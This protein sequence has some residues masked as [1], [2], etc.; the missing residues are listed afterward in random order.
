VLRVDD[1]GLPRV[2]LYRDAAGALKG[3]ALV[4][5]A[6]PLSVQMAEDY[7]D[8]TEFAPGFTVAVKRAEFTARPAPTQ[9][10][11]T[12]AGNGGGGNSDGEQ[13]EN[14]EEDGEGGAKRA[15]PAVTVS[16]AAA[17]AAAAAT[18]AARRKAKSVAARAQ[19]Q[20]LSW[21]D[22]GG[23]G[24]RIVSILYAFSPAAA[25]ASGDADGYYRR[26][27]AVFEDELERACGTLHKLTVFRGNEL[28][29]I[30]AKFK[31][32]E[33]AAAC[34]RLMNNRVFPPPAAGADT[35]V[36]QRL[37]CTYFDG[38]TNYKVEE[39]GG[40]TEEQRLE[41]F[42]D[43]LERED[44]AGAAPAAQDAEVDAALRAME[45][46]AAR[47]AATAVNDSSSDSDGVAGEDGDDEI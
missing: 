33:A 3:D 4:I 29:P 47:A 43:S 30:V 22:G 6:S 44:T 15:R 28:G 45:A 17:A 24:L 18:A 19:A 37:R 25:A 12:A 46:R 34:I 5:Y 32:G 16:A 21:G 31:S 11:T 36:D 27:K 38:K 41:A 23:A 35:G 8:G 20:A 7:L 13:E 40:M 42:G 9:A 1:D 2:K 10:H 14:E 26:V 39:T